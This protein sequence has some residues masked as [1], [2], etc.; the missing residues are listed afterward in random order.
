MIFSDFYDGLEYDLR[1]KSE[2]SNTLTDDDNKPLS[3]SNAKRIINEQI[4]KLLLMDT[5]RANAITMEHVFTHSTDILEMDDILMFHAIKTGTNWT[6]VDTLGNTSPIY[7]AVHRGITKSE[8]WGVGDSVEVMITMPPTE[9]IND[10]DPIDFPREHLALLRKCVAI[11]ASSII[12]HDFGEAYYQEHSQLMQ[13][14]LSIKKYTS[15]GKIRKT[16]AGFGN[17]SKG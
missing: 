14:W 6:Y 4:E 13:N 9:I 2:Y 12:K 8:A 17:R 11:S 15:V 5:S 16:G 10:N 3:K 1:Q 7:T